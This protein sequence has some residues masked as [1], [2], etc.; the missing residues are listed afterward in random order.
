MSNDIE[1]PEKIIELVETSSPE[2]VESLIEQAHRE[3]KVPKDVLLKHIIDLQNEGKLTLSTLP[4]LIP[5]NLGAYLFSVH[6]IWLWIIIILSTATTIL[7]FI[8]PE[9]AHPYVYYRYALGSIF[10]LFLPGYSL[11]KA[12][13]PTREID[14]IERT[15][16]SI[17]MSVSL[18]P[19]IGL[20]LNYTP[21]GLRLTP[22]TISLL[23]IT[24]IFSLVGLVREF[25]R[26]QAIVSSG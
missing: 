20:L 2:T 14:N 22:I 17:G 25:S 23:A 13:F 24:I 10:V 12:L 19:I 26:A 15:S 5:R 1:I 4:E 11:L 3:L 6:A 18:V 16:L 21:W 8:I 9:K 7:V